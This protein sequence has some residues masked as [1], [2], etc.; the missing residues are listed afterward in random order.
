MQTRPTALLWD[1]DGI[2]VDTEGLYFQATREVLASVGVEID[3]ALYLQLFLQAGSGAFHLAR[4]RG[5]SEEHVATLRTTRDARY[6]QLLQT[7]SLL[8][9]GAAEAV[10]SLAPL[11]RMA[12]VTSS[13][14]AHFEIIHR[15]TQ[16]LQHFE[17][18]LTHRDYAR[19]KPHPDPYLAALERLALPAEACLV[20]EDSERG[21]RAARAAGIRCW[22]VPS[23]LARHGSFAD[24][25][26]VFESLGA[27]AAALTS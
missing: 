27:L 10:A 24:A 9:D 6:A 5:I 26:R 17:F 8:Y 3:E 14:H 12:I 25:E 21:L 22:V 20:I 4:E 18:A 1:N 13:Q 16:L 2:L 23:R 19:T 7:G 15:S 11:Y